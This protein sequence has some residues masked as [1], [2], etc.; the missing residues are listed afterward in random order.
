MILYNEV[1]HTVDRGQEAVGDSNSL[2]IHIGK[3][4]IHKIHVVS[5]SCVA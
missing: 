1:V 3:K 5:E 2:R 4:R